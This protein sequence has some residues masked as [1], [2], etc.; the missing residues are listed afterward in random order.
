MSWK[1]GFTAQGD[2]KGATFYVRDSELEA[3]RRV[4]V[5]EYP[6]RDTPYAEDLGRKARRIQFEA[7]CIGSDYHIARDALIAKVEE[8]GAGTL[9]HPYH[10]TLTVTIT[11]FRVKE[12]TRNG[13]Y[14]AL[15]IQCVEAGENAFPAAATSTQREVKQQSEQSIADAINAFAGKFA[16]T[17][18]ADAVDNFLVEVDDV[19]SA[20]ANVTGSVSG[21]LADVIRAPAELGSA[22][23][24]AVTNISTIATE[25]QRALRIYHDL[26]DAGDEPT[27]AN[28]TPRAKQTAQNSQ[29]LTG[30][31]RT[32]AVASACK[33][34]AE[35]ELSPAKQGD[36]P[37][38][39]DQV[40]ALRAQLLAAIDALQLATDVVTGEP[41]DDTL[42]STLAG[43]RKAVAVDLS[44]RGSRLPAVIQYTPEAMLPAVVIAHQLYGDASRETELVN[45]NNLSHPGFVPGGAALEALSE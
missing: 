14:A 43:L 7:Y 10:G 26:F 6:E 1:D 40:Y 37:M 34:S 2:F 9:R 29:A 38:T 27:A 8:G 33:T 41:I 30:L 17:D 5:H 20:V 24:G 22:I 15:T 23:A 25:P 3:G 16:I 21:P 4:Q 13:G 11:S 19:F 18:V 44:T 31:V 45:L 39:R 28:S 42:F 36:N 12:S 32:A 35:L